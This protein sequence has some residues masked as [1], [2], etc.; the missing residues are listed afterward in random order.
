M[1]G[2]IEADWQ[3][4]HDGGVMVMDRRTT[5]MLAKFCIDQSCCF[6]S[7]DWLFLDGID[8]KAV[9]LAAKYLSMTSWY[10]HEEALAEI[11]ERIHALD[12]DSAGLYRESRLLDFDL[13][14]FSSVVRL[15][16][17]RAR[18]NMIGDGATGAAAQR[19]RPGRLRRRFDTLV[20]P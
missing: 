14:Y 10:G 2:A 15:G 6:N 11:V 17:A 12:D 8:P 4:A 16:I 19:P 1:G 20:T 18:G 7:P 9:A 5:D 13:P 3:T